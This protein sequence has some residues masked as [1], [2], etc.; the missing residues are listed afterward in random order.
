MSASLRIALIGSLVL[1]A[2]ACGGSGDSSQYRS[3]ETRRQTAA[4]D[5]RRETTHAWSGINRLS[6]VAQ[7]GVVGEFLDVSMARWNSNDGQPWSGAESFA[8]MQYRDATFRVQRVIFDTERLPVEPGEQLVI[9]LNGSGQRE[10]EV[11]YEGEVADPAQDADDVLSGEIDGPADSGTRSF[12][13]LGVWDA[14]PHENGTTERVVQVFSG[15][16]GNWTIERG[17]DGRE[18]GRSRDPRRDALL[19]DIAT[20]VLEERRIGRD[21]RRDEGTVEHPFEPATVSP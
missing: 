10:G 12:L 1:I 5:S 11:A 14:F 9:R 17:S 13:L 4:V 16:Q 3:L 21:P 8:A 15:F 6:V 2:G 7:A 18:I 20:R 19:D